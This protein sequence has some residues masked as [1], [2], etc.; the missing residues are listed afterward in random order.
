MFGL[1]VRFNKSYG[2]YDC[3]CTNAPLHGVLSPDSDRIDIGKLEEKEG[4]NT[5]RPNKDQTFQKV[6]QGT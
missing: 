4:L 3:Q 1:I 6:G 2:R 5:F